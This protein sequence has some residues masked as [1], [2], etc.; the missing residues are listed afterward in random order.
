M[1]CWLVFH[2]WKYY[3]WI[4]NGKDGPHRHKFIRHCP[5]CGKWQ[6]DRDEGWDTINPP[7][8]TVTLVPS[9]SPREDFAAKEAKKKDKFWRE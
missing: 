2:N 7:P 8:P 5:D 3:A 9:P 6:H 4:K 1:T